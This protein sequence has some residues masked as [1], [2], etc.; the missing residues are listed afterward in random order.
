V[1]PVGEAL[2]ETGRGLAG[3]H[4]ASRSGG[5]R[6]VTLV[7]FEHLPVIAALAG[8]P[9]LAPERLRRNLV[10]S[11][12]NLL[13]LVDRA[14]RAGD[15]VL[16]GTGPCHPCSRMEEALGPGGYNAVRGHGG[17]TARVLSGGRIRV[18]DPVTVLD[19]LAGVEDP[20]T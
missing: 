8:L 4:R 2:A 1:R 17:I 20:D 14:F 10:V 5:R 15:A 16:V 18:G 12:V 6:Q 19:E 13:A 9:T 11:G 7:Q 3:D